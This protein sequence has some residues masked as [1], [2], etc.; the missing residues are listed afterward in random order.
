MSAVFKTMEA[1]FEPMTQARLDQVLAIEASAYDHP[2][3]RGNFADSLR[4]GYLGQLL[5]AGDAILGYFVAMKGVDEVH[6]L[7]IT[8]APQCQGQ[9]W[10]RVLL[11]ALALWA[12]A[13]GAQWLWLEVRASNLRAQEIYLRYGYRRVGERKGY[14]PALV[15]R[16]DAIVMSYKL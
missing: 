14:Y 10:G 1:G 9:G 8:V 11:D 3:S 7:N 12:R 16:E 2:W 4:S 15:G 13:Q 5:C 6:L